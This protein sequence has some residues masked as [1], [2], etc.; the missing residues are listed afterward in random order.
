[1]RQACATWPFQSFLIQFDGHVKLLGVS[2]EVS[3][4][5]KVANI[6]LGVDLNTSN[7]NKDTTKHS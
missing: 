2:G 1:M 7:A 6:I 4:I 5:L 3:D